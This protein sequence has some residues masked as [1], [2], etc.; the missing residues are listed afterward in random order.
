MTFGC[1]FLFWNE[2]LKYEL[3]ALVGAQGQFIV[4]S[5]LSRGT[6]QILSHALLGDP[7]CGF[8]QE[9]LLGWP[10]FPRGLF[11][12]YMYPEAQAWLTVKCMDFHLIS[13]FRIVSQPPLSNCWYP[14]I[15]SFSAQLLQSKTP[16]FY[17]CPIC[18]YLHP[19]CFWFHVLQLSSLEVHL[20]FFYIFHFF[21]IYSIFC[22]SE[23]ME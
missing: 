21:T 2:S 16:I 7:Q 1:S 3:E 6:G 17:Q 8:L 14:Q 11:Q 12:P 4:P 15:Q 10:V 20:G 22:L 19:G 23:Q 5:L 13:T 18:C 9:F